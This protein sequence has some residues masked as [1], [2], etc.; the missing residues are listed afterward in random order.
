MDADLHA[1]KGIAKLDLRMR[2]KPL[3]TGVLTKTFVDSHPAL[4]R[5]LQAPGLDPNVVNSLVDKLMSIRAGHVNMDD[6]SVA[7]GQTLVDTY[8]TPALPQRRSLD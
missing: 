3:I 6:A 7:V 2:T 8:I 4:I 5:M 1:V